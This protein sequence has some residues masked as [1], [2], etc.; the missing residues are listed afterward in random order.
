MGRVYQRCF[1][2]SHSRNTRHTGSTFGGGNI[3]GSRG[4]VWCNFLPKRLWRPGEC[5]AFA[6]NAPILV[7]IDVETEI[8]KCSTL[9]NALHFDEIQDS[10]ARLLL[11][12]IVE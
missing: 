12:S 11:A 4:V 7:P 1:E 2:P 8:T 10:R 3:G 5:C 9:N 6:I